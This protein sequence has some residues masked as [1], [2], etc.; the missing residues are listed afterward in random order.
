MECGVQSPMLTSLYS[1]CSDTISPLANILMGV[2][3][4]LCEYRCRGDREGN[5]REHCKGLC[6]TGGGLGHTRPRQ[7]IFWGGPYA[8]T[9]PGN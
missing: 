3:V 2:F 5:L 1:V 6:R 7:P 9:V 4:N 8:G